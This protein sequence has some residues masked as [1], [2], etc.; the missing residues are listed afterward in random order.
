MDLLIKIQKIK[1]KKKLKT[2]LAKPHIVDKYS[3]KYLHQES[4]L[5]FDWYLPLFFN[6]KKVLNMKSRIKKILSKL[7]MK[8]N[9]KEFSI[10]TKHIINGEINKMIIIKYD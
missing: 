1:P 8:L 7:Y 3:I 6:H 4:D 9:L 2:V 10:S 5:F